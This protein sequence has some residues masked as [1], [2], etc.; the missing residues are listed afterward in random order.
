MRLG[1]FVF[2][3]MALSRVTLA[4]TNE[5][6]ASSEKDFPTTLQPA[7]PVKEYEPQRTKKKKTKTV[8]YD[9]RKDY[10]KRIE[11]NLNE[12]SKQF[13]KGKTTDPMMAPYLVT[14]DHQ[15]FAQLTNVSYARF[16]A[17]STE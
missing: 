4:Q 14:R 5:A 12:R 15:K 9:A 10:D 8:T 17:L 1:A 13:Q 11:K 6:S 7:N 2:I 16:V 3:M